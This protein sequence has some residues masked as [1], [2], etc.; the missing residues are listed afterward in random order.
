MLDPGPL[1][2]FDDPAASEHRFRQAARTTEGGDRAVLETQL[3]RALGLQGR[4][5]EA[6]AVLDAVTDIEPEAVV[7]VSLERGRLLRVRRPTR[8][9]TVI[10]RGR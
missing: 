9:V 1:W 8:A 7:R 3:A 2:N 10:L 5:T 6:H 4:Y